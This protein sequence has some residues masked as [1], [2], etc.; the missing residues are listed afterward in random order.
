M[1]S[2]TWTKSSFD[3]GLKR[4]ISSKRFKNSGLNS[5]V[6]M[7]RSTSSSLMVSSFTP[8]PICSRISL[9]PAL[10]VAMIMQSR[11]LIS[12]FFSSRRTPSSR[13]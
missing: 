13:T 10:D 2:R 8:C 11:K 5:P 12:R 1:R 4:Q 6:E 7:R 3:S 9:A